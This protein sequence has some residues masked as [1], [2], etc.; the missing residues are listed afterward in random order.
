MGSPPPSSWQLLVGYLLCAW[1]WKTHLL[2]ASCEAS[3][4]FAEGLSI[5]R[6]LRALGRKTGLLAP[7]LELFPQHQSCAECD[8]VLC[9]YL[10]RNLH[11][12]FYL[13]SYWLSFMIHIH[14][15][16]FVIRI[17]ILTSFLVLF[18]VPTLVFLSSL[19]SALDLCY[20]LC[21]AVSLFKPCLQQSKEYINR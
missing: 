20:V 21:I 14:T 13:L 15:Y 12:K 16:N 5:F 4:H 11:Y 17:F 1:L 6:L 19:S 10:H 2:L 9:L 3:C 7:H 18:N 8:L